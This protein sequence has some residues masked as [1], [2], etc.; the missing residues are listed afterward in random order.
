MSEWVSYAFSEWDGDLHLPK[1]R[2]KNFRVGFYATGSLLLLTLILGLSDIVLYC[3]G[4]GW[5]VMIRNLLY[6]PHPGNVDLGDAFS[7]SGTVG[8]A[9]CYTLETCSFKKLETH[10]HVIE[11]QFSFLL[12]E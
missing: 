12:T 2:L 5:K 4:A 9:V 11:K 7:A 6:L 10:R 8:G 1:G 3:K